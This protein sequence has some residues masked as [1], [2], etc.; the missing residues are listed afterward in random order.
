M[1]W[2]KEIKQNWMYRVY[3]LILMFKVN[4][5]VIVNTNSPYASRVSGENI[6][7]YLF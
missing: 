1:N 2:I 6:N 4:N 3:I 7:L 5:K